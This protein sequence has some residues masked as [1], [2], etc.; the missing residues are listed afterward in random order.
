[1]GIS[2]STKQEAEAE[3]TLLGWSGQL[4]WIFD[5]IRLTLTYLSPSSLMV[6]PPAHILLHGL[7]SDMMVF[8]LKT[9]STEAPR[10]EMLNKNPVIQELNARDFVKVS[11]AGFLCLT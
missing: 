3:L 7:A 1:V 2:S 8:S 11:R 5:H 6:V 9:T 4:P 10:P